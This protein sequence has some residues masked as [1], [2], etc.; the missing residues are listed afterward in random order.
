MFIQY[1]SSEVTADT[2]L[3]IKNLAFKSDDIEVAYHGLLILINL[4]CH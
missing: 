1:N 4:E 2:V 3:V